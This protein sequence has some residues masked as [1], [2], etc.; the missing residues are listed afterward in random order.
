ML[1]DGNQLKLVTD[2]KVFDI[3]K[4]LPRRAVWGTH[5]LKIIFS[6]PFAKLVSSDSYFQIKDTFL[7]D[8]ITFTIFS[9]KI[10]FFVFEQ[11]KR[12]FQ[13]GKITVRWMK[14]IQKIIAHLLIKIWHIN[15]F[16]HW[17]KRN[18]H[19]MRSLFENIVPFFIDFLTFE[20]LHI[21][22]N[23]TN[24]D[25]FWKQWTWKVYI[26]I[27]VYEYIWS[28]M[29]F[30]LKLWKQLSFGF[31]IFLTSTSKSFDGS[32]RVFQFGNAI[33]IWPR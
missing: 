32:W 33:K 2:K 20:L 11:Y 8:F 24:F 16:E 1:R 4:Y 3:F 28:T 29:V 30:W 15:R 31:K 19:I 9:L 26:R 13:W 6:A 17:S 21:Y 14:H 23:P 10:R 7:K 22:S 12:K 18:Q 5:L 25:S 27:W